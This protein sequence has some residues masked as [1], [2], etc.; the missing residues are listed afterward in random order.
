MIASYGDA[1]GRLSTETFKSWS[2]CT[3]L[4]LYAPGIIITCLP[5][6]QLAAELVV[7]WSLPSVGPWLLS[8]IQ[9]PNPKLPSMPASLPLLHGE[10]TLDDA[11]KDEDNILHQ[12]S[13]PDV[14]LEFYVF[15]YEHLD[16][17]AA[18]VSHHL[19]LGGIH[20]CRAAEVKEWKSGSFNVCIPFDINAP[21]HHV[22]ERVLI[23][24]PLPYNVGELE[25][26]LTIFSRILDTSQ[27]TSLLWIKIDC[28][29]AYVLLGLCVDSCIIL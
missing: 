1:P 12:L 15:L 13:Y 6:H 25:N 19:G 11:L 7:P 29:F 28:S 20:D 8:R 14:R 2:I 3:L 16:D 4:V 9:L 21:S 27:I 22:G 17:I 26:P 5:G 10:I 23:R 24:F 18:I